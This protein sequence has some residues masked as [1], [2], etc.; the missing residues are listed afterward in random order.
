MDDLEACCRELDRLARAKRRAQFRQEV[1]DGLRVVEAA[2]AAGLP[3]R[4]AT[5]A[6][7]ALELGPPDAG[8]EGATLTPLQAW[9]AKRAREA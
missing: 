9:R 3:V 1:A 8:T 6:G 5:I 4:A 7:V 2:K